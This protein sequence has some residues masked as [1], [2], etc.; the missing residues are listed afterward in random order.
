MNVWR[1]LIL[2]LAATVLG[3]CAVVPSSRDV[4]SGPPPAGDAA[5]QVYARSWVNHFR[6]SVAASGV[7]AAEQQ[8]LAARAQLAVQ[9]IDEADCE[10]PYCMIVP[11]SGG[12]LDSYCGYRRPDPSGRELYQWIP[13]R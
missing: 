7:A 8:L 1:Y 11:L 4:A 12:R 5:C 3:A 10:L 13:F 9:G 6:A 2:S